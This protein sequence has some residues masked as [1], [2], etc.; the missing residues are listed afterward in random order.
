MW[1]K[2]RQT[3]QIREMNATTTEKD[4]AVRRLNCQLRK[5]KN[6]VLN[7]ENGDF[8]SNRIYHDWIR[9]HKEIILPAKSKYVNTNLYYDLQCKP[10]DYFRSDFCLHTFVKFTNLSIIYYCLLQVHGGDDATSSTTGDGDIEPLP[11]ANEH[12]PETHALG[13]SIPCLDFAA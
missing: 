5:I 2:T 9:N 12:H 8:K 6:D 11:P 10:Q 4:S 13:H 7:I 1:E 3:Q